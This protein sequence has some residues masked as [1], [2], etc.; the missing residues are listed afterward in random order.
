MTKIELNTTTAIIDTTT[1][2]VGSVQTFAEDTTMSPHAHILTTERDVIW[3]NRENH[4]GLLPLMVLGNGTTCKVPVHGDALADQV[5]EWAINDQ[6][7]GADLSE[8]RDFYVESIGEEG[9]RTLLDT[10]VIDFND[11]TLHAWDNEDQEVVLSASR[12][13]R[14]EHLA[15]L[16]DLDL[17]VDA[18]DKGA[19]KN[20]VEAEFTTQDLANPPSDEILE[21]INETIFG[22]VS[23]EQRLRLVK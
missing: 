20:T 19:D 9:Y 18:W 23:E 14:M 22:E 10:D 15:T 6:I 12:E 11:I 13:W 4:E 17:S 3:V 2:A 5:P 8:R 1:A 7:N 16:L 21:G